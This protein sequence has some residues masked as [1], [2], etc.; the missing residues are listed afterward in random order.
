[1][2]EPDFLVATSS[3]CSGGLA[4]MEN[5]ARHFGRDLFVLHVPQEASP[6]GVR[7]LADQMRELAAF[8]SAHTGEPLDRERLA[9]AVGH[10]NAARERMAEVFRL[11]ARTPSP[12]NGK[13]LGNFGIVM[14]LLLGTPAGEAVARAYRDDFRARAERGAPGVPGE[15]RRLL[16]IQNR[17]Q[18]K[19]PLIEVLEQD[20]GAVVVADELNAIT[21]EPIDPADPFEGLARRSIS[22]PF[23]GPIERRVAHLQ[24]QAREYR[25]D[26]AINP[27]HWGCRQGTGARGLIAEGLRAVGVPVLNL[28]VDCIDPRPFAEGQLRTR[29]EAFAE[30]LESRPSPWGEP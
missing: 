28:E 3:P 6:A 12:A 7:Y 2:P 22:I 19:H 18:F 4:V 16:W 14:A 23:N 27:C 26:G 24:A 25:V 8:V 9:A 11:A 29:L 5:L 17:I 30:M 21:W 13:V 15:R 1:M 20:Y 10:T